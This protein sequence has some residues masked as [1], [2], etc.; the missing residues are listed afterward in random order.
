M[1][2]QGHGQVVFLSG[3]SI[4]QVAL[5]LGR[6]S[7]L[8]R[9]VFDKMKA[10]ATVH[11]FL[12]SVRK[13]I[14]ESEKKRKEEN[15]CIPATTM[16]NWADVWW[17]DELWVEADLEGGDL[18]AKQIVEIQKYKKNNSGHAHETNEWIIRRIKEKKTADKG[19]LKKRWDERYPTKEKKL[20]CIRAHEFEIQ[21]PQ[22][23]SNVM[24]DN[25]KMV[26][27]VGEQPRTQR[28][29]WV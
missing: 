2:C 23:A 6:T 1:G 29:E 14:L 7:L 12:K 24:N 26:E 9:S 10:N 15:L 5:A 11:E 20:K 13:D 25:L 27:F 16:K 28:P 18:Y 4:D 8:T 21:V 22:F 19:W 17:R 3:S